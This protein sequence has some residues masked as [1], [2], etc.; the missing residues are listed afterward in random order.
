M[1]NKSFI[2][3][4]IYKY[5]FLFQFYCKYFFRP[6]DILQ[7]FLDK[8]SKNHKGNIRFIQI[9][10]ND[11]QW[12]DPIYKY[13]RRDGWQGILIEPQKHIFERLK[14]N[15]KKYVHK[16]IF[17][18]VAIDN[19]NGEKLLYK[20][21]FSESRWAS[22][23]S[24]FIKEDLQKMIDAGYV[25]RMANKDGINPPKD[26]SSWISEE[27]V[28]VLT[29]ETIIEKYKFY[30]IDLLMIDTEGY[31]FEIIKTVPF[32]IVKP[33]VIVYEHSHFNPDVKKQCEEFLQQKSYLLI[34]C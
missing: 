5:D 20:I 22:G 18:N 7:E 31:D 3:K 11:G 4:V 13:I 14:E 24:S 27:I 26:R 17:L 33:S 16:L 1:A 10:A 21:S 12:N 2:R 8:Y 29:L 6:K 32:E 9:G 34:N 19:K 15:Y 23:L 28:K 30:E 25:E